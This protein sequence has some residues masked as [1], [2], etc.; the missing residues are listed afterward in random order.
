MERRERRLIRAVHLRVPGR[1][2]E[3]VDRLAAELKVPR[4]E[5]L[6]E[7]IEKGLPAVAQRSRGRVAEDSSGRV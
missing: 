1:L 5:V 2:C 7:A 4:S 6:R 3:R